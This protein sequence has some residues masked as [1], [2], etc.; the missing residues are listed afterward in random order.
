MSEEAGTD[1][2]RRCGTCGSTLAADGECPQCGECMAEP[3]W[4]DDYGYG[5]DDQ[6]TTTPRE[7]AAERPG[8]AQGTGPC[9]VLPFP[10][11]QPASLTAAELYAAGVDRAPLTPAR[12]AELDRMLAEVSREL[13]PAGPPPRKLSEILGTAATDEANHGEGD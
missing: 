9:R 2:T 7:P 10:K 6:P 12:V 8:R 4:L 13:N 5:K 11:P 1:E 3:T